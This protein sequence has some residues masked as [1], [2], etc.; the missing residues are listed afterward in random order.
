MGQVKTRHQR[1]SEVLFCIKMVEAM[2][3]WR[4]NDKLVR[5]LAELDR[6]LEEV[7]AEG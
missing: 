4:R 3:Q 1:E 7:R 2:L 5:R 6:E